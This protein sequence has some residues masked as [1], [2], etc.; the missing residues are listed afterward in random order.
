MYEWVMSHVRMYQVTHM[1]VSHKRMN[2]FKP[3]EKSIF[4]GKSKGLKGTSKG[5]NQT[6]D[7]NFPKFGAVSSLE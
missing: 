6:V 4:S 2:V 7:G 3:L 5:N 1:N